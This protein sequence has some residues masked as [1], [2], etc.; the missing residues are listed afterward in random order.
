MVP[1]QI[2]VFLSQK[3]STEN[4]QFRVVTLRLAW[5]A[6]WL[7]PRVLRVRRPVQATDLMYVLRAGSSCTRSIAALINACSQLVLCPH[8]HLGRKTRCGIEPFCTQ[9][10]LYRLHV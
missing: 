6:G 5:E 4:G 10:G 1:A 3:P 9:G 7:Q 2:P 8:Y